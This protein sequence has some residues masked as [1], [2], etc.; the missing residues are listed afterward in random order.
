[1]GTVAVAS[2]S[3]YGLLF[4]GQ[5]VW[6][7][8]LAELDDALRGATD[9][10]L[11]GESAG[12]I[13]TWPKLDAIAARFPRARVSGAP[14]AGFYS[15][16]FP[17][18]GPDATPADSGLPSFSP[19]GLRELYALYQP[20]LNAACVAAHA[21][22]PSPCLLSNNSLPFIH[23][24]VFV[25][26]ALTDS[27]QL[28]SHDNIP[29]AHV[30]DAPEQAYIAAWSRNMTAALSPVLG[31]GSP[32]SR[33]G[34]AAACFMHT[35]FTSSQPLVGGVSFLQAAARWYEGTGDYKL[36]DNCP[37]PFCNPTCPA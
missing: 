31:A 37:T 13:A 34:F 28:T 8:I 33:G 22:D 23:T 29:A 20:S 3:T 30:H 24:D 16:A 35:G 11:S 5:L 18:T 36:A 25:T 2:A 19:S 17:Y 32:A 7:A 12:G 26:E 27:V 21:A 15:N 4:S 9:I 6:E 10:M 14:I 1:M